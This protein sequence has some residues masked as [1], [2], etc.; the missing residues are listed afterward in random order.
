MPIGAAIVGASAIGAGATALSSSS[1]AHRQSDAAVQAAQIQSNA[2][3]RAAQTQLQMFGQV[4]E[5]LSPYRAFGASALP[6][7]AALLGLPSG[8]PAAA[9]VYPGITAS[10]AGNPAGIPGAFTGQQGGPNW[11][12]YLAADPGIAQQFATLSDGRKA[13][14]GTPDL[15]SFAQWHWNNTGQ[16]EEGRLN[17]FTGVRVGQADVDPQFASYFAPPAAATAAPAT[18]AAAAPAMDPGAVQSFLENTPGYQFTKQQGIKAL[19]SNLASRGL[20]GVDTA[21]GLPLGALG[22]GLSRFVTGL[23]DQ[24]YGNQVDRYMKAIG[25][26]QA[27]AGTTAQSSGTAASG[28]SNSI[29]QGAQA[30]ASGITGAANAGAAG[31][32]AAGNAVGQLA[33]SLPNALITDKVLGMY[34]K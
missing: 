14:L 11:Q 5:D 23:A 24:T 31:T 29:T 7:A 4:R 10:Y 19:T 21:T 26:G 2:A 28:I 16:S 13:V 22:K 6:G 27:A 1:A 20:S 25:V 30:S 17:P 33:S 32:I 9:P 15:Q 12:A 3:D 8:A 34:G 18:T